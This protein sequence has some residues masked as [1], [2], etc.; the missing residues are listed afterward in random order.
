MLADLA[1]GDRLVGKAGGDRR[2][3]A[4]RQILAKCRD[5]ALATI[6]KLDKPVVACKVLAAERIAPKKGFA[7]M[8]RHLRPKDGMCVGVFPQKSD[9]IIE[10]AA[11]TRKLSATHDG[12]TDASPK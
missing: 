2:P 5:Q 3:K 6:K 10:N 11:L 4:I 12:E 9:E 8:L 1:I 7:Q